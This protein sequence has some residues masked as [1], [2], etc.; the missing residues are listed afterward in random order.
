MFLSSKGEH[1]RAYRWTVAPRMGFSF[2][3]TGQRCESFGMWRSGI[4][5][6]KRRRGTMKFDARN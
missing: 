2:Y 6:L 5:A 4:T 3:S 1:T